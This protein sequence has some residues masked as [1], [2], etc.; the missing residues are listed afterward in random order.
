MVDVGLGYDFLFKSLLGHCASNAG[1]GGTVTMCTDVIFS[2]IKDGSIEETL[3]HE[4]AHINLYD[5]NRS[6]E[7]KCAR[8]SD[9]HYISKYGKHHPLRYILVLYIHSIDFY[10]F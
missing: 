6:E 10:K 3:L 8:F 1:P 4:N 7:W 2:S 9:K 5:L